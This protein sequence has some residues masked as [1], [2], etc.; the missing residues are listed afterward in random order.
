MNEGT[1]LQRDS[2]FSSL[3]ITLHLQR[4]EDVLELKASDS[5]DRFLTGWQSHTKRSQFWYN[6]RTLFYEKDVEREDPSTQSQS[7]GISI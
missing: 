4:G 5:G 1:S 7:E 6:E 2:D 3:H